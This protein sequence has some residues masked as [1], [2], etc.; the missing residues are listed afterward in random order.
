MFGLVINNIMLLISLGN[1]EKEEPMPIEITY[2][3]EQIFQH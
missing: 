1:M 2:M 3:Q